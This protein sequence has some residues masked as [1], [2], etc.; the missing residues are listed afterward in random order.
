MQLVTE[1]NTYEEVSFSKDHKELDDYLEE[2]LNYT[3][4]PIRTLVNIQLEC[5]LKVATY[6]HD[7]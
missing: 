5:G 7:L 4:I 6:I 2:N 1:D 3:V